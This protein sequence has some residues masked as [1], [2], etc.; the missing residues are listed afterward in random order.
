MT[1]FYGPY[2]KA[3]KC[4]VA[5]TKDNAFCMRPHTFDLV[6]SGNDK[7]L[8]V[9]AAGATTA[10]DN[11]CHACSGNIG[12]FVLDLNGGKM[13][14]RAKSDLFLEDGSN[15]APTPED[16]IHVRQI[17]KDGVYGWTED[18]FWMGQGISVERTQV[19]A[20]VGD[21]VR[22]LGWLPRSY[23]DDGDCENGKR[24]SNNEPCSNFSFEASFDTAA[25]HQRFANII[26]RGTGSLRG[27][28]FSETYSVTFD[29]KSFSYK[30]P[31]NLPEEAQD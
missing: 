1:E 19:L 10:A 14:V 24:I 12:Y 6:Q 27:E 4:W 3:R 26:L 7:L 23:N 5:K 11:E 13:T 8:Y 21:Q 30:L 20:S 28:P 22:T 2:N 16:S 18:T 25:P 15:G 31:K 17:G 9:T 29:E